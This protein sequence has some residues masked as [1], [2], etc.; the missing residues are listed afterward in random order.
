MIVYGINRWK[1]A[2]ASATAGSGGEVR[3]K[4]GGSDDPPGFK[5]LRH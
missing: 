2:Q 1:S 4:D 3:T 5:G